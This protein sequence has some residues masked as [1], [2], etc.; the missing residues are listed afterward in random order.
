M[1]SGLIPDTFF[2]VLVMETVHKDTQQYTRTLALERC[3]TGAPLARALGL[4]SRVLHLKCTPC[5]ITLERCKRRL[6]ALERERSLCHFLEGKLQVLLL[7]SLARALLG[8]LLVPKWVLE[9]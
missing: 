2:L 4:T 7:V 8:S 5:T 6:L 3:R 9:C 1:V